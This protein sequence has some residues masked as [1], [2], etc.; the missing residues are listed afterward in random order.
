MQKLRWIC[1]E[2]RV[3]ST[4]TRH[5]SSHLIGQWERGSIKARIS[6]AAGFRPPLQIKKI[7]DAIPNSS[8][9]QQRLIAPPKAFSFRKRSGS[10]SWNTDATAPVSFPTYKT[11]LA[12]LKTRYFPYPI[13]VRIPSPRCTII[14]SSKNFF[15]TI[16]LISFVTLLAQAP[17][18]H[19]VKKKKLKFFFVLHISRIQHM[20]TTDHCI[21]NSSLADRTVCIIKILVTPFF[22]YCCKSTDHF[23][24]F[25]S[26]TIE[27]LSSSSFIGH[28]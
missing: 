24:S 15:F 28:L 21:W 7:D 19:F 16:I 22:F 9:Q 25:Q 2:A 17:D 13:F 20:Y 27:N 8:L 6:C 5:A 4:K 23:F 26:P 18:T 3:G 11:P 1:T 14:R 12:E 10:D